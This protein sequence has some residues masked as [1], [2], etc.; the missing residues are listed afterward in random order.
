MYLDQ[1]WLPTGKTY[2]LHPKP[3][4]TVFMY[5]FNL[6]QEPTESFQNYK[7]FSV[8]CLCEQADLLQ[9]FVLTFSQ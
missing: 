5:L 9:P 6:H 8:F 1:V 7:Q 3:Y 4:N 2:N